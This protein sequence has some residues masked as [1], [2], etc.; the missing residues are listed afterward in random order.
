MTLECCCFQ[1]FIL[2]YLFVGL[3]DSLVQIMH[4]YHLQVSLQEGCKK[5]LVSDCYTLIKR[6]VQST[7]K[8]QTFPVFKWFILAKTRPLSNWPI[9]DRHQVSTFG[10]PNKVVGISDERSGIRGPIF[11]CW[12]YSTCFVLDISISVKLWH[13]LLLALT[14][15]D[16]GYSL[17]WWVA[18][19]YSTCLPGTWCMDKL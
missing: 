3:R 4:D 1:K 2:F 7:S 16:K 10:K 17:T 12:L 18:G 6:Q 5:I 9:F 15:L 11:G 13:A 19:P 14:T 8:N